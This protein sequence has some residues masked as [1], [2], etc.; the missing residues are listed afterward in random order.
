M[1]AHHTPEHIRKSDS[2]MDPSRSELHHSVDRL[3]R[4]IDEHLEVFHIETTINNRMFDGPLDFLM[5]RE[6]ALRCWTG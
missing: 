1:K 5:K 4:V 2:Y 6:D 3:G